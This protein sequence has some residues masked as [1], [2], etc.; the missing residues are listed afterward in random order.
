MLFFICGFKH[1]VFL[2]QLKKIIMKSRYNEINKVSNRY[3][4]IKIALVKM[5]NS[6]SFQLCVVRYCVNLN[7]HNHA[8]SFKKKSLI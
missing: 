6:T 7:A 2:N 4:L 3:V 5:L 1:K 8:Y